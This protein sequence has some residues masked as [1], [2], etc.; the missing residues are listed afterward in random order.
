MQPESVKPG[1]DIMLNKSIYTATSHYRHS[2][3][4][5]FRLFVYVNI[6][7]S[8][9]CQLCFVQRSEKSSVLERRVFSGIVCGSCVVL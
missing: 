8:Y 5:P 7:L 4:A 9:K 6:L 1:Y 2:A 3:P